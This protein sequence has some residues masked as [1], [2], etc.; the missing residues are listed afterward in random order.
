MNLKNL[1]ERD[2]ELYYSPFFSSEESRI[3]FQTIKDETPW[4]QEPIKIFGREVMQPRL[5]AWFGDKS[6]TY[7]GITMMPLPW[8]KTLLKIKE[9]IEEFSGESFNTA[10]LNFYRN[11][12]DSMGWHRD[13]ERELG[14]NPAIASISFGE[15]RTFK[16]RH[17]KM[18]DLK[19][20]LEVEDGSFLL[21]KGA[22]QHHWL[23]SVARTSKEKEARIN[24][25]FRKVY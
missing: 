18:P 17:R 15:T 6:Y 20:S 12:N 24:I 2:G 25:T 7:S 21:M 13:D 4:K 1:L 23:H 3:F 22:S 11:Q 19:L 5:T 16:M 9:K 10:L 14:K 8:T